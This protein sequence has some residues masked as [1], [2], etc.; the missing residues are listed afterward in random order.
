MCR[1]QGDREGNW[2]MLGQVLIS[3]SPQMMMKVWLRFVWGMKRGLCRSCHVCSYHR[4]CWP[5][6]PCRCNS[7]PQLW[8]STNFI[9]PICQLFL[10]SWQVEVEKWDYFHTPPYNGIL[11]IALLCKWG[12]SI[13]ALLCCWLKGSMAGSWAVLL[14]ASV[15]RRQ[16]GS[17]ASPP[18]S[19]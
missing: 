14:S 18:N 2:S 4:C 15:S 7:S 1:Q 11:H 8:L 3:I 12:D 9:L 5:V 13:P 6:P 17:C 16:H 10:G 19:S